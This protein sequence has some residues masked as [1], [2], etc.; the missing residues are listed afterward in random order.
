MQIMKHFNNTEFLITLIRCGLPGAV[1]T[2]GK[3]P[4]WAGIH[5]LITSGSSPL[6]RV[7]FL[8]T[9]PS[10]VTEYAT[11]RKALTN[12][13]SCRKQQNQESIA[14][15]SDEGVFRIVVD[16]IMNEPNDFQ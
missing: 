9:I 13:Q 12:F 6:M 2:L 5:A 8:P 1:P 15:V 3:V 4:P 14:V 16:I 7:G 11:V 10:P